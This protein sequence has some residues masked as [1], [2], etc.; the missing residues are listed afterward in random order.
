[1]TFKP[2]KTE[3]WRDVLQSSAQN[4]TLLSFIKTSDKQ[5][6]RLVPKPELS[7]VNALAYPADFLQT[8]HH[9]P[10]TEWTMV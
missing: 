6:G 10:L 3:Q 4:Q 8:P 1:M 9:I 2:P 7:T 5:T